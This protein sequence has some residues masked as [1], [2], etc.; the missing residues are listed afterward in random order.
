MGQ[1]YGA[2]GETDRAIE[3]LCIAEGL[4]QGVG[5]QLHRS[6]RQ[7]VYRLQNLGELGRRQFDKGSPTDALS[8]FSKAIDLAKELSFAG[9]ARKE[10][11]KCVSEIC[12]D[13]SKVLLHNGRSQEALSSI[14]E[15]M[16]HLRELEEIEKNDDQTQQLILATLN[17]R[18]FVLRTLGQIEAS[19]DDI[20]AGQARIALMGNNEADPIVIE[21]LR[22]MQH[23]NLGLGLYG[24]GR[25]EEARVEFAKAKSVYEELV[26]T[27][28]SASGHRERL[29]SSCNSVG[30]A[31]FLAGEVDQG[32]ADCEY[33]ASI[34][35]QLASQHPEV[36]DYTNSL[37]E[38]E[39][40]LAAMASKAMRFDIA[41]G[42]ARRAM[43][44]GQKLAESFP[45]VVDFV[46]VSARSHTILAGIQH[47]R[48]DADAAI[49][50]LG[51]AIRLFE[52][53]A[54][55]FREAVALKDGLAV[56]LAMRGDMRAKRL[57]YGQAVE[58][59][60]AAVEVVETLPGQSAGVTQARHLV[61]LQA[62]CAQMC[63]HAGDSK[64]AI[65]WFERVE[66]T[67]QRRLGVSPADDSLKEQLRQVAARKAELS[68]N[69]P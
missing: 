27:Y 11:L 41:E 8:S 31:K 68:T 25:H 64:Q 44:S 35:K 62:S 58:D 69:L 28:P 61:D 32:I 65:V 4:Y 12:A 54:D 2:I 47:Q 63:I 42:F 57:E 33:A 6:P 19:I 18:A 22:G 3:M 16:A 20:R 51:D 38:V 53:A 40:N 45:D 55:R 26:R 50:T 34:W 56:A 49:A 23:L 36:P 30:V 7:S 39:T 67:L 15:A 60:K 13:R 5:D 14:D 24:T 43:E 10:W 1:I 21:R 59:Y 9:E 52:Q 48:G 29:A 37:L 46:I 17:G 66:E